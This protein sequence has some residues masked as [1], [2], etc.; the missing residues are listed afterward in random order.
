MASAGRAARGTLALSCGGGGVDGS[1]HTMT[2]REEACCAGTQTVPNGSGE[3][4][5][6]EEEK[7][8][9]ATDTKVSHTR[10][11]PHTWLQATQCITTVTLSRSLTQL[12]TIHTNRQVVIFIHK[13]D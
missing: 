13:I 9:A 1:G 11:Q 12:H 6:E 3:G 2:A 4:D 10:R 7:E 5:E 8:G